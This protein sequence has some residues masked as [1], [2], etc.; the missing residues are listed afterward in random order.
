MWKL[1]TDRHEAS[2]GFFATA[3]LF[4]GVIWLLTMCASNL[5]H[6]LAIRYKDVG[7]SVV[8][9]LHTSGAGFWRVSHAMCYRIFSNE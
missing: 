3:E 7:W 6:W 2:R 4:V 1:T 9:T 8:A 5:C